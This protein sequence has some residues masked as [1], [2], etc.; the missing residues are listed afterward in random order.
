MKRTGKITSIILLD[1]LLLLV[2]GSNNALA[3]GNTR[4][5]ALEVYTPATVQ[6]HDSG[7]GIRCYTG[8]C[9]LI[10][11]CTSAFKE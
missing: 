7:N 1:I 2:A 5:A 4:L 3:Q 11:N 6:P 8:C 9:Q 10:S